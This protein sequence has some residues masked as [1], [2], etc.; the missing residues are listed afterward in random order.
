MATIALTENFRAS[1]GN[2]TFRG[3]KCVVGAGA[4]NLTITA[5]SMDMN[6]IDHALINCGTVTSLDNSLCCLSTASGT[7]IDIAGSVDANDEFHIMVV[8]F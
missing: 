6:R 7:Y 8:G 2:K 4:A 5:A 1:I 3:F